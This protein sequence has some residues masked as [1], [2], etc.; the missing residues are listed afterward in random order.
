[1]L[2]R[3]CGGFSAQGASG[4]S[5]VFE[6]PFNRVFARIT[7]KSY[8]SVSL[9]DAMRRS[10]IWPCMEATMNWLGVAGIVVSVAAAALPPVYA[11]L[12]LAGLSPLEV[13]KQLLLQP[14]EWGVLWPY[15]KLRL[16]S[17][18]TLNRGRSLAVGIFV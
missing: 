16:V 7:G 3:P 2:V 5:T 14:T 15:Y 10:K 18:Y 8:S 17:T 1:M 13:T 4:V 12:G 6:Y 9:E 11:I